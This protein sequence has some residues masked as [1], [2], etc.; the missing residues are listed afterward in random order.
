MAAVWAY[1]MFFVGCIAEASSD[2]GS[3]AVP[4]EGSMLVKINLL[5]ARKT[6]RPSI[7]DVK[8]LIIHEAEKF[9]N[10]L[11]KSFV[12]PA[13]KTFVW[14]EKPKALPVNMYHF[15]TDGNVNQVTGSIRWKAVGTWT[16]DNSGSILWKKPLRAGVE[17]RYLQYSKEDG[18]FSQKTPKKDPVPFMV[19]L[20]RLSI[21]NS[22]WVKADRH[23]K[24]GVV[25]KSKGTRI[26]NTISH[27]GL[28]SLHN[29]PAFIIFQFGAS[30]TLYGFRTLHTDTNPQNS[31]KNFKFT[32]NSGK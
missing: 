5:L 8:K 1:A 4:D 31:F 15:K 2:I 25:R 12:S 29:T 19:E 27:V 9:D 28:K 13:E 21:G 14:Y 7:N 16:Q 10:L 24:D 26:F 17:D 32:D 23:A 6:N 3:C 11:T 20:N 18:K 30:M 22:T